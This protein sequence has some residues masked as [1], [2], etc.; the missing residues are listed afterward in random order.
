MYY[1]LCNYKTASYCI[2]VKL[3]AIKVAETYSHYM[4]DRL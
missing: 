4:R 3:P 1:A 2:P